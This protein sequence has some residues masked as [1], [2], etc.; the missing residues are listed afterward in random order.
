MCQC[1]SVSACQCVSVSV[2]QCVSVSVCQCVSA[3]V[4]QC[5]SG[6]EGRPVA[7]SWRKEQYTSDMCTY[8]IYIYIYIYAAL[9]LKYSGFWPE[10]VFAPDWG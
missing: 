5:G 6:L 3:S 10:E 2:C 1:V 7:Q 8:D 4:R 9:Q